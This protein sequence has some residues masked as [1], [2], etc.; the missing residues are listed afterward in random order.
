LPTPQARFFLDGAYVGQRDIG[1]IAAGAE[2]ELAFGPIDGLRLIRRIEDRGEGARGI[3]RTSSRIT[4]AVVIEVENLTEEAWPLRVIDRVP[5]SEQDALDI[6]WQADPSPTERD[7]DGD[8]G[9]LAWEFDLPAGATQT[10][11]LDTELSWPEDKV[12]R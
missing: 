1:L 9:I 4:E 2:A 3:I 5:V 12:L 6:T 7:V 11:R 10:I 8:R